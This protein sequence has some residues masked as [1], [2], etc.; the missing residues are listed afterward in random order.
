MNLK[1][2]TLQVL[3][4]NGKTTKD[5]RW[6][7]GSKYTIPTELFWKLADVEYNDGF[8]AQEVAKDLV[9]VGDDWWL[10][11]AEYDGSEWWEYKT[12]PVEPLLRKIIV[13]VTGGMWSM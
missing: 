5:I 1:E 4:D 2:E 13:S 8:G 9:V 11:R 10:E 6:V 7:G 3:K 12:L